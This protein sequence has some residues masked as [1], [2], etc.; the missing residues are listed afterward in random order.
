VYYELVSEEGVN[1]VRS[2]DHHQERAVLLVL[3]GDEGGNAP[4]CCINFIV[5]ALIHPSVIFPSMI[6]MN[7]ISDKIV[8]CQ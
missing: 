3:A 4:S 8:S 7:P 2:L 6:V 5:S 1:G